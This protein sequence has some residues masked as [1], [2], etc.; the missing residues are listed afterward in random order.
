MT[1]LPKPRNC[2]SCGKPL[3]A[4]A[5]STL[6]EPCEE[7]DRRHVSDDEESDVVRKLFESES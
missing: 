5:V 2:L 7:E 1:P 6:C 3:E 4:L